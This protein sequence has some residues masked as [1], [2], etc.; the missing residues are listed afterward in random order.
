MSRQFSRKDF[1]EQIM[2]FRDLMCSADYWQRSESTRDCA[3]RGIGFV[4]TNAEIL[5]EDITLFCSTM[6]E[7]QRREYY[8]LV[9]PL[10]EQLRA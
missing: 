2:H 1:M 8:M 10:F 5:P 7:Y 6:A 9:R 3:V 4:Y